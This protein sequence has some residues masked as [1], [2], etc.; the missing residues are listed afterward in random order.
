MNFCSKLHT[1]Y[2]IH[3]SFTFAQDPIV[4][5]HVSHFVPSC[6]DIVCVSVCSSYFVYLP[7][8]VSLTF[9]LHWKIWLW[10]GKP[11]SFLWLGQ[12]NFNQIIADQGS[13][14]LIFACTDFRARKMVLQARSCTQSYVCITQWR[15]VLIY[16]V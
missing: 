1:F 5:L 16:I 14:N 11:Y 12:S 2:Y 7:T 13:T 3:I 10:R 4:T 6:D 9:R 15:W 8:S